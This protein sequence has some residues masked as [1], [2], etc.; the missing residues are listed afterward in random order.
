MLEPVGVCT[1][2]WLSFEDR[3]VFVRAERACIGAAEFRERGFALIAV[4]ARSS[5]FDRARRARPEA[6]STLRHRVVEIWP[7]R[8]RRRAAILGKIGL[9]SAD[10]DSANVGDALLPSKRGEKC[11]VR[12]RV[13]S[14]SRRLRTCGKIGVAL[15]AELRC[16]EGKRI[17]DDDDRII[18]GRPEVV[19]DD[20]SNVRRAVRGWRWTGRNSGDEWPSGVDFRHHF[21]CRQRAKHAR[22]DNVARAL[23]HIG[24]RNIRVALQHH[25]E[26][27][28]LPGWKNARRT[29]GGAAATERAHDAALKV[30]GGIDVR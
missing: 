30:A 17:V 7:K 22:G 19:A 8:A 13:L 5:V 15:P 23:I 11:R 1:E 24:P 26:I 28:E 9:A 25:H 18:D 20:H 29:V 12:E 6:L 2:A 21:S 4:E 3:V 27:F 10:L 14:R 16:C